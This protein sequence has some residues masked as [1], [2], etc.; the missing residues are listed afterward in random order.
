MEEYKSKDFVTMAVEEYNK[1]DSN[2]KVFIIV[3]SKRNIRRSVSNDYI[4]ITVL[5]EEEKQFLEGIFSRARQ[6]NIREDRNRLSGTINNLKSK[7]V[8]T[9]E[10]IKTVKKSN[11]KKTMKKGKASAKKKKY[12]ILP[13]TKEEIKEFLKKH[14]LKIGVGITALAVM[15]TLT[16]ETL[17]NRADNINRYNQEFTS[18]EQV[19]AKIK[20]II[21]AEI[22]EA[23]DESNLEKDSDKGITVQISRIEAY[24]EETNDGVEITITITGVNDWDGKMVLQKEKWKS[25]NNMPKSLGEMAEC[26]LDVF[27]IPNDSTSD[28]NKNIVIKKLKKVEEIASKKDFKIEE[29][30]FQKLFGNNAHKLKAIKERPDDGYE[31]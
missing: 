7:E 12:T 1:L 10:A 8:S 15:G 31:R 14:G 9:R 28:G 25:G 5:K 21:D 26:Y 2:G 22:N 11:N 4:E 29:S 20:G 30:L 27:E 17:K 13:K 18:I 24:R 6:S 3:G 16:S 23:V 19:E